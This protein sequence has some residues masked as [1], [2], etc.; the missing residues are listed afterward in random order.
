MTREERIEEIESNLRSHKGTVFDLGDGTKAGGF[1]LN[2]VFD[3]YEYLIKEVRRL[4]NPDREVAIQ[5][6]V[7]ALEKTVRYE[8]CHG[9]VYAK[10]ALEIWR[11]A[12]Q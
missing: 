11:K 10:E 8:G 2:Q 1:Y 4:S 5:K 6:M 3:D 7:E 9:T 12:N